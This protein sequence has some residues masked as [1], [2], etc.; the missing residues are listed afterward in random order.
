MI[1]H[2]D[3]NITGG[4]RNDS[5]EEEPHDEKDIEAG[6][7]SK[8]CSDYSCTFRQRLISG[9]LIVVVV[10]VII[11]V[12]VG[13]SNNSNDGDADQQPSQG[14]S[15]IKQGE[16]FFNFTTLKCKR[17][18]TCNL[19]DVEGLEFPVL[20]ENTEETKFVE[21][22]EYPECAEMITNGVL[23]SNTNIKDLML[24]LVRSGKCPYMLGAVEVE[25]L[26]TSDL[27][28]AVDGSL[29]SEGIDEDT[30]FIVADEGNGHSVSFRNAVGQ[31][32]SVFPASGS[33]A[34][35]E[36]NDGNL[37]QRFFVRCENENIVLQLQGTDTDTDDLFLCIHGT[38]LEVKSINEGLDNCWLQIGKLNLD[39]V[40]PK[41]PIEFLEGPPTPTPSPTP[42]NID[43]PTTSPTSKPTESKLSEK[44]KGSKPNIV[45]IMF[46][47]LGYHDV[48]WV[49]P[50]SFPRSEV[51]E[52]TPFLSS[53][54]AKSIILDR[55]YAHWHCS[56]SRRSFLTGRLPHRT[57][58]K[59]SF[60]EDDHSDIRWTWISEKLK[61]AG[62]SNYYIGKGHTG[63]KS[64]R[65]LPLNRGFDKFTGFLKGKELYLD[66]SY[67]E[68]NYGGLKERS[69][70]STQFFTR[71]AIETL[72]LHQQQ[73]QEEPFFLYLNY[74]T[75]HTPIEPPGK[76]SR[77]AGYAKYN[78]RDYYPYEY[79]LYAADFESKELV[80]YLKGDSNLWANTFFIFTS[81]N[82]A[83]S[84]NV[85]SSETVGSNFPLRGEK[86]TSFE[87][88]FRVQTFVTGGLIPEE[89]EGTRNKLISHV[90][91]WYATFCYLAGVNDN[92]D[93]PNHVPSLEDLPDSIDP[94]DPVVINPDTGLYDNIWASNNNTYPGHDS[95][96]ILPY[97]LDP[98]I[99]AGKRGYHPDERDVLVLSMEAI[100]MGDYKLVVAQPC[101]IEEAR[102]IC[103]RT[104][105]FGWMNLDAK[106]G[107]YLP[108]PQ[109]K[110][111]TK[112]NDPF[113]STPL[114]Y[115]PCL[116]NIENDQRERSP[117][118]NL[119]LRD[120][121]WTA[122][123]NSLIFQYNTILRNKHDGISLPEQLGICDDSNSKKNALFGNT[124]GP[125]CGLELCFRIGTEVTCN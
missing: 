89:L 73:K 74:Q 97:L 4:R 41:L 102:G 35:V 63:Y 48:G 104:K 37:V 110:G 18:S 93:P 81:D 28:S 58:E 111:C 84:K 42:E 92:D 108:P 79:M 119:E 99:D 25:H 44:L 107:S 23:V 13:G 55:H 69:E 94:L 9:I 21:I 5:P 33:V 71:I 27:V 14:N 75:P 7:S 1:S 15:V 57:E 50:E 56:P 65:H 60:P 72:Q 100:I 62:Y 83:T 85:P 117:I 113:A 118:N 109:G 22:E 112:I 101:A 124:E 10:I 103:K 29:V 105:K 67:W 90:A 70:Y 121:L 96:N 115:E 45:M 80:D 36:A 53:L 88:A 87:G 77:Y 66:F 19:V 38:T 20:Y 61:Q 46:D 106:L 47:D 95:V 52:A 78:E 39:S 116:F 54:A 3:H 64:I 123:N 34:T 16:S 31:Y 120:K 17:N 24:S 43:S 82:G 12:T 11:A 8:S 86:S 114:Q 98:T 6:A 122:L 32:L 125:L 51:V 26:A 76:N 2:P 40:E 30:I 91:D 59:L 68:G 49:P